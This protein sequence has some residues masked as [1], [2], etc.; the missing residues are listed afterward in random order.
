MP[1]KHTPIDRTEKPE[2]SAKKGKEFQLSEPIYSFDDVVLD[3]KVRREI[4]HILAMVKYRELLYETWNL[5]SV[6]P[7]QRSI[8]INLY[9]PS[10]TGKTMTAHA[11]ANEFGKKMLLVSY[12]EIESKFVGETSKNLV[13]LFDFARQS[14]A[15]LV[16]DEAD[17]LLSKRVT[18]MNNATDVSVNQT[19]NVLLKLLDEYQGIVIFTTN[20]ITNYDSAFF[21][22]I[23]GHIEFP[24][25]D[26]ES[27]KL[28][29]EHYLVNELPLDSPK[30]EVAEILSCIENATGADISNAVL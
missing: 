24:L 1:I 18:S 14:E 27:R 12:A 9:G 30:D 8:S 19:R 22:R 26:K 6:F 28:I 5:K 3:E 11:I 25:P 20:F 10:G 15:V 7:V 4:N 17:A 16:F 2:T 21:R 13:A 29:W 23:L